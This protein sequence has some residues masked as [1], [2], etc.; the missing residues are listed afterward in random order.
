MVL[1]LYLPLKVQSKLVEDKIRFGILCY[2]NYLPKKYILE[3][4]VNCLLSRQHVMC[5]FLWKIR[6]KDHS[7]VVCWIHLK[8]TKQISKTITKAVKVKVKLSH[9]AMG[10]KSPSYLGQQY[11]KGWVQSSPFTAFNQC[12]AESGYALPLQTVSILV[13]W[14]LQKPHDLLHCLLFSMWICI[15]NLDQIIWLADN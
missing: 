6:K 8:Y 14:L 11:M 4:H 1:A 13:S 5:Y 15:N 9:K 3:F 7:F 12:P 10:V 2:V